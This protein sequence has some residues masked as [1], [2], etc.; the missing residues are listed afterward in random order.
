LT[1]G[2][3]AAALRVKIDRHPANH[4]SERANHPW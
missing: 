2:S 4:E 3:A 1:G